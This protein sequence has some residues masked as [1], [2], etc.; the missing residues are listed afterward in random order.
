MRSYSD[1]SNLGTNVNI[2]ALAPGVGDQ[3]GAEHGC[4]GWLS[5]PI[6]FECTP[7]T[8]FPLKEPMRSVSLLDARWFRDDALVIM[9]CGIGAGFSGEDSCRR[10]EELEI[11]CN[12]MHLVT[13]VSAAMV[14]ILG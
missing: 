2:N 6:G 7:D 10:R 8:Q 3:G 1:F 13:V 9:E 5:P 4:N 14:G 12:D 11:R